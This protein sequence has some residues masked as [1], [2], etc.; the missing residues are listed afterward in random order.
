MLRRPSGTA[1]LGRVNPDFACSFG[2]A[3]Q[4]GLTCNNPPGYYLLQLH[5]QPDWQQML[6]AQRHN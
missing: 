3:L 1:F 4:S 5:L 6:L 2:A